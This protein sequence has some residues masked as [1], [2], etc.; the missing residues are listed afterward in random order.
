MVCITCACAAGV[1]LTC[2]QP[3]EGPSCANQHV[4][5]FSASRPC[6]SVCASDASLFLS[7]FSLCSASRRLLRGKSALTTVTAT[8][9]NHS[10]LHR[11]FQACLRQIARIYS[12]TYPILENSPAAQGTADCLLPGVDYRTHS[13][14]QDLSDITSQ[15]AYTSPQG[16]TIITVS[17]CSS[18]TRVLHTAVRRATGIRISAK[19]KNAAEQQKIQNFGCSTGCC[20]SGTTRQKL[21][22][23][24]AHT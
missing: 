19:K 8:C 24:R 7:H 9:G 12:R 21:P 23:S 13:R 6:R 11:G 20:T 16:E 10:L 3:I 1:K 15:Y 2:Y 18:P 17:A 5:G 22:T 4:T 14:H